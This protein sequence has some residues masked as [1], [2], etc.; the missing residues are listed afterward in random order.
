M[1]A[2]PGAAVAARAHAAARRD[3]M[4]FSSATRALRNQ[5]ALF[6]A[7][8]ACEAADLAKLA[9]R[10][11]NLEQTSEALAQLEEELER[12]L[13]ALANLGKEVTP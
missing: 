9:G 2:G 11:R 10:E 6:S 8:A 4:E 7:S 12:L 3:D 5:L 1:G 13:P